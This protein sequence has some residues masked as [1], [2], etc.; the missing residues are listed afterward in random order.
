MLE[1]KQ[2]TELTTAASQV[3]YLL[4]KKLNFFLELLHS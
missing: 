4:A 1:G 3:S 2:G